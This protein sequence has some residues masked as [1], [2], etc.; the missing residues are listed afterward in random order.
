MTLSSKQASPTLADFLIIVLLPF[1][2]FEVSLKVFQWLVTQMTMVC[3]QMTLQL[4]W[5]HAF[6]DSTAEQITHTGNSM[7]PVSFI[8]KSK[9]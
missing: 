8:S 4:R 6:V 3:L 5:F 9:L 7:Q 1:E 2:G